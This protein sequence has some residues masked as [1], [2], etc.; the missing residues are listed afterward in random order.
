M[1]SFD[2][3]TIALLADRL[4]EGFATEED[5]RALEEH[6]QSSEARQFLTEYLFL[7]GELHWLGG[8]CSFVDKRGPAIS[9][10]GLDRS[11]TP[12]LLE[13]LSQPNL[14]LRKIFGRTMLALVIAGVVCIASVSVWFNRGERGQLQEE[15]QLPIAASLTQSYS[16]DIDGTADAVATGR[17]V[18][19]RKGVGQWRISSGALL[20]AQA[21]AQFR[22]DENGE[23]EL[24]SGA[25]FVKTD[26]RQH[27]LRVITPHAYC[28]DRGTAF[29]VW[30]QATHTEVHVLEGQVEI[31]PRR[32][33]S[34][35]SQCI[36]AGNAVVCDDRGR[37][38]KATCRPERF[39]QMVP[40]AKTVAAYR[41]VALSNPRLWLYGAFESSAYEGR[42]RSALGPDDFR[43]VLMHGTMIR[44]EV[45]HIAGYEPESKA[46]KL[47]R[48][49]YSGD[50]V[51]VGLQ[52]TEPVVFP[53]SMTV[54]MI[55]RFDGWA[56]SQADTLGCLLSTRQDQR[57]W[58]VLL[59]VVPINRRDDAQ[60]A[61]LVHLFD[62][63]SPWTET[64]GELVPGCW[65]YVVATFERNGTM[66]R[67][68]TWLVN[69]SERG[70]LVRVM[71]DGSVPGNLPDGY[72]GI[73]K[74]FDPG[75]A[76]A[77]PFPGAID[78]L[79]IY[80]GVLGEDEIRSHL[81]HLID[82]KDQADV[83]PLP[84]EP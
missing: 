58:G 33:A 32:L 41:A 51:G 69:L 9:A 45:E 78:E 48:G 61:R 73:G 5:V 52:T 72:L 62:A 56:S 80:N 30:C 46:V 75:M 53:Q 83:F 27:P 23:V 39:C 19:L 24:A 74:G 54:E 76:H 1:S 59:G 50:T 65:H 18:L 34:H 21:P 22:V 4:L 49:A 15:S 55:V 3:E 11:K 36:G 84:E 44:L 77:Y 70:P 10:H 25:I 68:S 20:I 82:L 66:T 63:A 13:R 42:W 12:Q 81:G 26:G 57:R 8:V 6:V 67:V 60:N 64:Q 28:V 43:P 37:I 29:G 35:G 7:T 47:V 2:R 17:W 16:L 38:E 79:A 40:R 14:Q 71:R 31:T